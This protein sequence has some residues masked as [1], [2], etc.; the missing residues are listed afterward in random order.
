MRRKTAPRLPP[1]HREWLAFASGGERDCGIF[2]SCSVRPKLTRWFDA[3][4]SQARTV[5]IPPQSEKRFTASSMTTSSDASSKRAV[6]RNP[7]VVL[8]ATKF[9]AMPKIGTIRGWHIRTHSLVPIRQVSDEAGSNKDS[10]RSRDQPNSDAKRRTQ[11]RVDQACGDERKAPSWADDYGMPLKK[12]ARESPRF[13][14]PRLFATPVPHR[15]NAH[16]TLPLSR[17]KL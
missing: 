12:V 3:G 8:S 11:E 2:R 10:V 6:T 4:G 5:P 14:K 13:V 17:P 7:M 1:Q 16:Q 15:I 9:R